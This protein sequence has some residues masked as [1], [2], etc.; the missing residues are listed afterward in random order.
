MANNVSGRSENH[1]VYGVMLDLYLLSQSDYLVCTFTSNIC[2][3]AYELIQARYPDASHR[4]K[5]LD[6]TYFFTGQQDHPRR[7]AM[8]HHPT[9]KEEI[10]MEVNDTIIEMEN[11]L[12]GFSTGANLRTKKWGLFPSFKI[13]DILQTAVFPTY[14]D[15]D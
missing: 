12:N 3:L 4:F 7:M 10:S 14:P 8:S 9:T 13:A 1:A 6:R 2:R 5:S 11:H 15:A